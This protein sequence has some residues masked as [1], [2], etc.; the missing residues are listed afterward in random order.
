MPLLLPPLLA[1]LGFYHGLSHLQPPPSPTH[2]F[3]RLKEKQEAVVAGTLLAAPEFDG[4]LSRVKIAS[5]YLRLPDDPRYV[6]TQGTLFL[7]LAA[8]WPSDLQPGDSLVARAYLKRPESFRSPGAFDYQRHLAFQGILA[9]GFSR[10]PHFV[11]K[12]EERQNFWQRLRYAPERARRSIGRLI[13][14]AVAEEH[15]GLY[16]A[17]LI[18]DA[19]A[20]GDEAMESF[21]ASGTVHILS[22]SGLHMTIIGS[23][24]YTGFYWLLS[25]SE[26]LLINCQLRKW[27][28]FLCL[29]A[30]LGYG[31]LAGLNVPVFRA[32]IMSCIA[33]VGICS[34]RVKS[35]S[36]LL[37]MAALIILAVDPLSLALPS[38]QLSFVATGAI[39]FLVPILKGVLFADLPKEALS[40]RRRSSRWLMAG[41]VVSVAATAA[42]APIT[43]SAFN[44]VSVVGIIANLVVEPLICLWSLPCGFLALP[45]SAFAPEIA[46]LL[47]RLGA[48]GLTA[49]VDCA[50]FFANLPFSSLWRPS[51][52]GWLLFLCGM[53]FFSMLVVRR[54]SSPFFA[55][56]ALFLLSFA[57]MIFPFFLTKTRESANTLQLVA[58]DVGQ[59][60]SNLVRFP[61]GRTVLIDGGGSA[62][63]TP[64]V[65]ERVIAPYLWRQGITRL[66][67]VVIT[68]P[69]ADHYNGIPF[70][71]KHFTPKTLWVRDLQGHDQGY[72]EVLRLAARLGVVIRVPEVGEALVGLEGEESLSCLATQDELVPVSA[73]DS[74]ERDNNGLVLKA[75]HRQRCALLPGDIDRHGEARL[76][77]SGANLQADLLVSPHHGS[78]SSNSQQFLAAV[79][80][81]ILVVSAGKSGQ[82]HFPHP[83]L[84]EECRAFGIA[85]ASTAEHGS[86]TAH[87]DQEK[88]ELWG[89][90]R[91]GDN[92]FHPWEQVRLR[93]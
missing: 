9:S 17:I 85:L 87:L 81:Q 7:H 11:H 4:R 84:K 12:L 57:A 89:Y 22:I 21:K 41:I 80:P 46:S 79:A 42:T 68:H 59:G 52:P 61:S 30:L 75:C 40:L 82:G 6:P 76:I 33:I 24:L 92:P 15:R 5:S 64:S 19:S 2:L 77:D 45:F 62:A 44:R 48:P 29:P 78:N 83:H 28:A 70:I 18:G 35:P 26:W 69:D 60:S 72:Q 34:D 25:R 13:D 10:S 54:R 1:L 16:R 88:S 91:P 3:H 43:L 56:A 32:M 66:D 55:A 63:T 93:Q 31:L 14:G 53:A 50:T 71:L 67:A 58:L 49:A 86:L 23:L 20:I 51:P 8:P 47:L 38:F 74:M 39:L 73:A 37:A 90:N 27:A 65:G 36:T